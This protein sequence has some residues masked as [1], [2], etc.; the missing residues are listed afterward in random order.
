MM[1]Y[2]K[3]FTVY[4]IFLFPIA[5]QAQTLPGTSSKNEKIQEEDIRHLV[6]TLESET[7]RNDLIRDLK[8]L[9]E[10]QNKKEAENLESSIAPL[11]EQMGLRSS[12]GKFIDSY[13]NFLQRYALS[14]SLVHQIIGTTFVVL[15]A[16]GFYLGVRRL[17]ARILNF[18]N[19]MSER[20]GLRLTRFGLY[21]KVVQFVLRIAILG[22]GVY[23]IGKIWDI[24]VIDNFFEGEFM[25]RAMSTLVTFLFVAFLAA[26]IWEGIGV[27]LAYLLKQADD[28]NQ[29]RVKT[30]MPIVR[31]IIMSVFALLFGLILLSELGID[32]GPLIAGAGVIGVAVG[33]GAQNIVKDFLAGFT[34]VLE[35]LIRVGDV[36][37]LGGAS[38]VVEKITL[39][40]VQLRDMSGTVYTIPYSQITTIQ[41]LTKD[42]SFYV[43]DINV[44]YSEDTDHVIKVMQEVDNDLRSDAAF[45]PN[46]LEPLEIIGLDKFGESA[47][48]IKAR[49]KTLPGKQ[50]NAGR[51]YNRRLKIAFERENIEIPLTQRFIT[52]RQDKT[53][54]QP[55]AVPET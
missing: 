55:T 18:V 1:R 19:H 23:T 40:K 52:V 16:L 7:A 2:I 34:I 22:L 13:E 49:I 28:Q 43:M 54:M 48:T 4:L 46:I 29:T 3:I 21:T 50:W 5:V 42:F 37:N 15:F 38:G 41:N 47:V 51:E 10:Q 36:A 35:D 24:V 8:V 31:N 9:L 11:T 32:V 33:F 6:E 44:A 12:L 30:L 26:L 27:Y 17:T 53:P 20:I 45:A 14:S 39:R 25:R